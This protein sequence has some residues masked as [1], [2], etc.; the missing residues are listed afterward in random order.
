MTT[1]LDP[2]RQLMGTQSLNRNTNAQSNVGKTEDGK[3][4]SDVMKEFVDHVDG[5]QKKFDQAIEAVE[6]GE[7]DNLHQVMLAQNQAQVSNENGRRV[8]NRLVDA[9]R[10]VMR[11]QF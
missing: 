1:P 4:F 3:S 6:R 2:M 5:T 9:Y 11:T 10:E 8:R 7:N